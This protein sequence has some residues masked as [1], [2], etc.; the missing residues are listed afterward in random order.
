MNRFSIAAKCLPWKLVN[1]L[2]LTLLLSYLAKRSTASDLP[3][4]SVEASG[5]AMVEVIA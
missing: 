2:A 4:H 1:L 5:N 3:N